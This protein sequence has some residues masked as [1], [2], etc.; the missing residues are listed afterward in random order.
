[1][2]DK[3]M[4][5]R[6]A[7]RPARVLLAIALSGAAVLGASPAVAEKAPTPSTPGMWGIIGRNTL[8]SPSAFFRDGP[9][10]RTSTD[11]AARQ[12]PPYGQGSLQI[13]VGDGTEK[14]AFGNETNFSGLRL[15]DINALTYWV[16]AGTDSLAG[17]ALPG[18]ALE[19]DPNVTAGVNYSSLVYLPN[20]STAPSS[21]ATPVPNV[22][23]H[24]NA[25]TT[26][27]AWF[28]TGATG[29][30]IGCTL[31]TPC[32]F[33]ELKTKLPNAEVTYSLGITKGRDT[34]FIGA[35]DGLQVNQFAYDFERYG[36]LTRLPFPTH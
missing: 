5:V 19:V 12:A 21:P 10:G 4:G 25:S 8:G 16:F 6:I 17:I 2:S 22:W 35:V 31:A 26:G 36:V 27:S 14:I 28:A 7:R 1:M 11:P 33:A 24:Y 3:K 34:A 13:I 23:Q 29:A 32:S 30:A 15:A 20:D 9:L 18:I